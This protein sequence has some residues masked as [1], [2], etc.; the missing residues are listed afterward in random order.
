MF[1][2]III[3]IEKTNK[4]YNLWIGT[5]SSSGYKIKVKNKTQLKQAVSDYIT[6]YLDYQEKFLR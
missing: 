1:D 4:G 3:D 2:S 6:D 5:D